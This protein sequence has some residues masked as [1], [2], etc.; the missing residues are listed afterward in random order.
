MS[1][2]TNIPK[3]VRKRFS[4]VFGGGRNNNDNADNFGFG[5]NQRNVDKKAKEENMIVG[6]LNDDEEISSGDD[7]KKK[8][9]TYTQ[10]NT[11]TFRQGIDY[12]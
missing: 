8:K 4:N 10:N 9:V 3:E 6:S 1:E 5:E 7:S 2:K 12:L 11:S